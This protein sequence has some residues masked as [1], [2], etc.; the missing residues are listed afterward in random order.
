MLFKCIFMF[1]INNPK[2]IHY[3]KKIMST[4]DNIP[5]LGMPVMIH[6]NTANI[7]K[8]KPNHFLKGID[9]RNSTFY[10]ENSKKE[11]T[12]IDICEINNKNEM[13]T[14]LESD[15]SIPSKI[16]YL[17]LNYTES[18]HQSIRI[19]SGGLFDDWERDIE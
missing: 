7:T 1:V 14:Y 2:N 9:A 13:K 11:C 4:A 19:K 17:E 5:P 12:L 16:E 18:S 8:S 10:N 3:H 6:I 15:A